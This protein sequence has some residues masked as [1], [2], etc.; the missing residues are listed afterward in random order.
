[1]PKKRTIGVVSRE[2]G[3]KVTT[4][5]Y[6]ESVGLL[7]EPD[8]TESGQRVYE[9]TAIEQL[10][11]IR[12]ARAL[13]FPM[14]SI[15]ELVDLQSLPN[16][17]CAQVDEIATRQLTDVRRRLAQLEA[18]EAELERMLSACAG[19]RVSHCKVLETLGDHAACTNGHHPNDF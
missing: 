19:G 1:M 2:T 13:G 11:F 15:R 3:V 12:H 4:I 14:P 10:N 9:T 5:R 6:Y 16:D 8:R 18:L 7:A 17:S